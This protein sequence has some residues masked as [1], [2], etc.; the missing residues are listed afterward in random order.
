MSTPLPNYK[1]MYMHVNVCMFV[2]SFVWICMC[3]WLLPSLV[4]EVADCICYSSDLSLSLYL[5][6]LRDEALSNALVL[7]LTYRGNELVPNY[8]SW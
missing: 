5:L 6:A 1:Y 8:K 2:P 3:R 7:T 4:S